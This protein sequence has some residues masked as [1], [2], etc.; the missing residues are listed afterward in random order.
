MSYKL[1][2]PPLIEA[3]I[4]ASVVPAPESE[5]TWEAADQVLRSF[6]GELDVFE[7]LPSYTP[8]VRKFSKDKRPTEIEIRVEPRFLRVRDQIRSK[9]VQISHNELIVTGIRQ[10]DTEYPGFDKLLESF[11]QAFERYCEFIPVAGLQSVELHYVDL[12]VISEL[13]DSGKELDELFVG[14]PKLPEKPFGG[15]VNASWSTTFMPSK[16]P[17]VAQLSVQ[18]H[19]PDGGEGRFRMDWHCW[20]EEIESIDRDA[21]AARLRRAHNFVLECFRASIQPSVWQLFEPVP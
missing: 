21:I 17:I 16:P 19:P 20:C 15:V 11:L 6:G 4:Q 7:H 8:E 2:K 18:M 3:W 5:W 12:V 10:D 1:N 13:F 14:A 9:L